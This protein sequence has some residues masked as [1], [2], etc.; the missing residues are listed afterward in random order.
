MRL[1]FPILELQA[2]SLRLPTRAVFSGRTAG[3]LHGLNV[4]ACDPIEVTLP[5]L[6]RTSRLV[7]VSLTRSDL[8]VAEVT[9]VRG[10][11]ATSA[12]RTVA[13]LARRMPEVEGVI[14]IEAAVRRRLTSLAAL[15][16]WKRGS[17]CF[18][19]QKVCLG[20]LCRR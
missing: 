5:R 13:D 10:L 17:D 20:R 6:A 8:D 16:T 9:A 1:L 2:R 14:H 3:W 7:G 11:R 19:C 12:T 15:Q 4:P 18:L